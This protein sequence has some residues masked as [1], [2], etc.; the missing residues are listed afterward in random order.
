MFEQFIQQLTQLHSIDDLVRAVRYSP[1][2]Q[3]E[4][5]IDKYDNRH[6]FIAHGE[7]LTEVHTDG[8]SFSL[9]HLSMRS[10]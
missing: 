4:Y 9:S 6:L 8:H 5:Q 1:Y 10:A 2:A 7:Q 3:L